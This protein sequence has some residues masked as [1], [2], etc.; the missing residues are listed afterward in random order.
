MMMAV[1][2]VA[3][4]DT[5]KAFNDCFIH[6]LLI[7]AGIIERLHPTSMRFIP[8]REG[9]STEVQYPLP[10]RPQVEA[11]TWKV[12]LQV[13]CWGRI[14]V[15]VSRHKHSEANSNFD[16]PKVDQ[17]AILIVPLLYIISLSILSSVPT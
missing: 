16:N 2:A 4:Y 7:Y 14:A 9:I 10:E 5:M 11:R 1:Y 13:L 17:R 6:V 3:R 12:V 15:S 8:T